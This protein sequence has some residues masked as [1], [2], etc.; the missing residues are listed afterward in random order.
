MRRGRVQLFRKVID[1]IRGTRP[2][3][4]IV[5]QIAKRLGY[6]MDYSS[7]QEIW[8]EIS[9]LTP[10]LNGI[11]Y[12]R[13]ASGYGLCWPCPDKDHPGTPVMYEVN[14]PHGLGKF[15]VVSEIDPKESPDREYPLHT[16]HRQETGALQRRGR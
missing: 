1:P 13:L 5:C 2:D 7:P 8:D 14:F 3:W 10:Q 9:A 6:A 11:S 16:Y 12:D 4:E 15:N